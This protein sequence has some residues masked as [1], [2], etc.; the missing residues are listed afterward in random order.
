MKGGE[1]Y[2]FNGLEESSVYYLDY[3][4]QNDVRIDMN[5]TKCSISAKSDA[6]TTKISVSASIY[7]K[8]GNKYEKKESWSSSSKGRFLNT[9]KDYKATGGKYKV[10]AK[11]T[12]T[13][14]GKTE[15]VSKT[16]YFTL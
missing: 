3:V 9:S 13:C 4:Q 11:V 6:G 16:S 2:A 8:S 12:S 10:V 7:K 14:N 15:T 5:S 1:V